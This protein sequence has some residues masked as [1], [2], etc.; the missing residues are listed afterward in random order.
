MKRL[1]LEEGLASLQ[2]KENKMNLKELE[3]LVKLC[4]KYS[5]KTIST[6]EVSLSI[7]VLAPPK[8]K[9]KADESAQEKPEPQYTDEDILM[10]SAGQ[11]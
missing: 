5:I 9:L 10:W 4:H 2:N 6:P 3:K 8:Q 1:W 11:I 7:E